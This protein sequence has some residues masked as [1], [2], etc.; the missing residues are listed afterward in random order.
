MEPVETLQERIHIFQKSINVYAISLCSFILP[1]NLGMV[2]PENTNSAELYVDIG[3][4]GVPKVDNFDPREAT[5]QIE[6][7][8]RDVKGIIPF[9]NNTIFRWLIPPKIS[10]LKLTRT[11]AVKKSYENNHIIQDMLEPVETLQERIRIFQKSI[12]V[13]PIWLCPFILPQNPGM[14]HPENTNSAKLG[15]MV[16][17]KLTTSTQGRLLDKSKNTSEMS[18]GWLIPPKISLLE[19]TRTEAVKKL[20]ENNHIIQDIMEPVETL[21]E[22]IHIFQK[23]I[24][25]YPI[26]LCS[27]ILPQ[28]PGMVHPENT[29]SAKL[30]V[31]IGL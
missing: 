19:L 23:S 24:N 31:D 17:R 9:G 21:Q 28:N 22:R 10:L 5:R 3:L 20:Y 2:H 13:Y 6:K 18:K 30:Y 16:F 25:V 4:Y 7:Y 27:F 11:E 29:N 14:V 8:V 26:S 12:N 1:Q 15:C